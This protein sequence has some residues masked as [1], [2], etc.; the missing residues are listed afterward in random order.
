MRKSL[1]A[2][3][4]L[5]CLSVP[6]IALAEATVTTPAAQN[7]TALAHLDFQVVVPATLYLRVG[8]SAQ[9][10]FNG[11]ATVDQLVFVAPATVAGGSPVVAGSAPNVNDG[12][13]H[14]GTV[15]V[16]VYSNVGTSVSL[17]SNVSG[18]LTDPSNTANTI[19]W[20]KIAVASNPLSTGH[21]AGFNNSG[22]AHPAFSAS[23][24]GNGSATSLAAVSKLVAYEGQWTFTYKNDTYVPAGTYGGGGSGLTGNGRVTY[25]AL[26]L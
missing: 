5:V 20:S 24:V 6:G 21:I 10:L 8:T 18:P 23:D 3:A 22:I 9:P 26:Q 17:N 25:T 13:L 19:S 7:S 2:S 12:D 4:A 14:G 16:R 11:D 15:T 1:V